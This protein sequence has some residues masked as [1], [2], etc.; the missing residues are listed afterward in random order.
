MKISDHRIKICCLNDEMNQIIL[1]D[2]CSVL[3]IIWIKSGK[4]L[5]ERDLV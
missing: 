3:G 5:N 1:N 4:R 2:D